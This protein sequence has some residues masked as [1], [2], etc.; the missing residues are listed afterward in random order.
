MASHAFRIRSITPEAENVRTVM[1]TPADA[2]AETYSWKAGQFA[3]VTLPNGLER[4][5]TIATSP[6][7]GTGPTFTVKVVGEGTKA[8]TSLQPGTLI[9][10]SDAMGALTLPEDAALHKHLFLASGI[11]ITPMVAMI[12]DLLMRHPGTPAMLVCCMESEAAFPF[13]EHFDMLAAT[14]PEFTYR[15]F[16]KCD[17][18]EGRECGRL[19]AERLLALVPDIAERRVYACGS[20]GFMRAA[21]CWM[22]VL[23]VPP[24]HFLSEAFG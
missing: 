13:R 23:G 21:S 10:L 3:I 20:G 17:P 7:M 5:W 12:R 11:G 14:R 18:C 19:D 22:Q 15:A 1:L 4:P 24:N 6:L 2:G 9:R 16:V 8:L